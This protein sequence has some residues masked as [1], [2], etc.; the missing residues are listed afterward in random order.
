MKTVMKCPCGSNKDLELC[1]QTIIDGQVADASAEQLMRSRYTAY[2]Q[3]NCAYIFNTYAKCKQPDNPLS[4]IQDW[5]KQCQWL[6]LEIIKPSQSR[7]DN[8][9]YQFVEFKAS[10]LTNHEVWQMHECSRFVKE[11]GNWRYLDG[12]IKYHNRLK[13]VTGNEQ[14]PCGSPRKYKRCC[15]N[16]Q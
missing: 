14:C 1:C 9:Q 3:K 15:L 10:Y 8:N 6:K 12:D 7:A 5:A 16:S 13:L 11:D 4:E 2:A